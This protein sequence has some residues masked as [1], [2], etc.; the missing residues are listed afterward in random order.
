MRFIRISTTYTSLLKILWKSWFPFRWL[1]ASIDSKNIR[2]QNCSHS[3][4]SSFSFSASATIL[5][6]TSSKNPE[7]V[8]HAMDPVPGYFRDL[9]FYCGFF[10]ILDAIELDD[11][12]AVRCDALTLLR[13]RTAP[14]IVLM[15]SLWFL[16]IWR[17]YFWYSSGFPV[18]LCTLYAMLE[19]SLSLPGWI[20]FQAWFS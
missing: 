17:D 19:F 10:G 3:S 6:L 9:F 1:V 5:K 12:V 11:T 4:S 2:F 13:I 8:T 20:L 7:W 16:G 15:D 14:A 18:A